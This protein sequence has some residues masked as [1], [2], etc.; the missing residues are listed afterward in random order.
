MVGDMDL[1]TPPK[2]SI[3]WL[4]RSQV[5]VMIL[6]NYRNQGH[7]LF[8]DAPCSELILQVVSKAE[9]TKTGE[10]QL[11]RCLHHVNRKPL[12]WHFNGEE[13]AFA[14]DWLKNL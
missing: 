2:P 6:L 7:G 14:R 12:D 4:G 11:R 13:Y 9:A 10:R 5:P 8:P 1:I 3:E